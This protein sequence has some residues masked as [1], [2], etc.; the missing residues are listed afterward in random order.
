[1]GNQLSTEDV[2]L[3]LVTCL[4]VKSGETVTILSDRKHAGTA[5]SL[6]RG[7]ET[8]GAAAVELRLPERRIGHKEL[9][10]NVREALRASDAVVVALD[11]EAGCQLWHTEAREAASLA[12]AR[13]GLL[14]PPTSW[15]RSEE[16]LMATKA[17]TDRITIF[18]DEATTATLETPAGTKLNMSLDGR[19]AFSCHSLI[20]QRGESATIPEWGDAEISPV[21]G[22]ANGVV[23]FDVSMAYLGKIR[24]PIVV[25][26]TNG[27]AGRIEGGS[28]ARRLESILEDAG[29]S[30]R[31]IAELGI[32]TVFGARITGHKDDSVG[33][34]AH[35]ALGHNLTL[36]GTVESGVHLDGVMLA[37]T[38]TVDDKQILSQ[39]EIP[40]WIRGNL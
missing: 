31:N 20:R 40:A 37:P 36:G 18:L 10:A 22:S 2:R 1:M 9:P 32:G 11:P 30:S 23:V 17:I 38:L 5:A 12:G 25:E 27:L 28:Q 29:P 34:T 7:A 6:V 35:I 26:V 13:V 21:E 24:T 15:S 33:G 39:G 3:C 16:D 4:D 8:L 14:F 19:R